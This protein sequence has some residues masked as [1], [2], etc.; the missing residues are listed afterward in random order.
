MPLILIH[1]EDEFN[2]AL[3]DAG[4]KL[5][6]VDFFAD[7][8]G[9][10]KVIGP[11]FE[12]M[13]NEFKDDIVALKVDVDECSDVSESQGIECMP[14]FLF[15]KNTKKVDQFSGANESKLHQMILTHK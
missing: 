3:A 10:C 12:A 6:V 8:C 2:K 9:P 4:S 7:W 15:F 11:K 13:S 14:T 1:S 5:V